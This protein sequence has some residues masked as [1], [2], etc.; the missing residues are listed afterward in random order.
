MH[1]ELFVHT[2]AY[3]YQ[4]SMTSS[5][6][7]ILLN[8]TESLCNSTTVLYKLNTR[9]LQNKT[10]HWDP[11]TMGHCHLAYITSCE[12]QWLSLIHI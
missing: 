5:H 9:C 7:G 2:V 12:A 3:I 10:I 6:I 8:K 11:A 4:K 1:S